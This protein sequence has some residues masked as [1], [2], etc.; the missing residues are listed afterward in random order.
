M[1]WLGV[2]KQQSIGDYLTCSVA[3]HDKT[4]VYSKTT[5]AEG[6]ATAVGNPSNED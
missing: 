3:K 1:V 2:V 6:Q 5:L 4:V